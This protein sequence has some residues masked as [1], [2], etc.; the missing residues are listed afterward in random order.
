MNEPFKSW[1]LSKQVKQQPLNEL[2]TGIKLR[3]G[4]TQPSSRNVRYYHFLQ[5][6]QRKTFSLPSL[7]WGDQMILAWTF[8][9]NY[10]LV[11][12]LE[13]LSSERKESIEGPTVVGIRQK[14]PLVQLMNVHDIIDIY[15]DIKVTGHYSWACQL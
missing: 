9:L 1:Q 6:L 11:L 4:V 14:D 8:H 13:I 10:S 7:L 5:M 2:I 12:S 15:Y 3:M